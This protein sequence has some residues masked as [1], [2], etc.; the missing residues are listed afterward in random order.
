VRCTAV[1]V[2]R[3][4]VPLDE[5]EQSF[6]VFHEYVLW[7]NSK[8]LNFGPFGQYVAASNI[9]GSSHTPDLVYFQDDDCVTSPAE[10]VA[11]WEPSKIVCNMPISLGHRENYE[12]QPDK[13]MG[14][15][16]VFKRSLIKETFERYWKYFPIDP[17]C[18]REP[19]RIFTGLNQER[20]KLADVPVRHL[21]WATAPDRLY[22]QKDHVSMAQEAHRRVGIVLGSEKLQ[23]ELASGV[24][25]GDAG[26]TLEG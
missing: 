18:L 7:N 25:S 17:V 2:T 14:F 21:E 19:G 11:Q 13:L 23:R 20:I 4:N 22:R 1:L 16:S 10:I 15:G 26:W 12:N 5:V 8:R 6:E 9:H 3:G 24:A